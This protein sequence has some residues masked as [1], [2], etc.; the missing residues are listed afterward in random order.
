MEV[1][2][3]EQ[4]AIW[5]GMQFPVL[6]AAFLVTRWFVNRADAVFEKHIQRNDALHA[7]VTKEKDDRLADRD[8]RIIELK[9]EVAELK[10]KL[11]R[12]GKTT[13]ERDGGVS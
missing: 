13:K 5:L 2:T 12:S 1:K 10:S 3:S 11:S 6:A 4:F 9:A 7:K 8:D